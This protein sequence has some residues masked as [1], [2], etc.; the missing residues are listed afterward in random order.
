VLFDDVRVLSAP[1]SAPEPSRVELGWER[2]EQ[3][4]ESAK[5]KSTV[6]AIGRTPQDLIVAVDCASESAAQ[7]LLGSICP[8]QIKTSMPLLLRGSLTP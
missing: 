7:Q 6:Q 3:S 8:I 5:A 4:T 1:K 2:K